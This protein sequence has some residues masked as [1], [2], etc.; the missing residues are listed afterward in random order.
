MS[1]ILVVDDEP[2]IVESLRDTLSAEDLASVGAYDHVSAEELIRNEFFP[3]ILADLRLRTTEEGLGLLAFIKTLSPDSAVIT[4]TGDADE[5]IKIRLQDLGSRMILLKPV[6]PNVLVSLVREMLTEI[7]ESAALLE[8]ETI[9]VLYATV[10]P[11]LRGLAFRRYGFSGDDADELVQRAWLLYFEKRSAIRT[12]RAWLSGTIL[13][14]CKQEIQQRCRR[15]SFDDGFEGPTATAC[16]ADDARIA[17]RQALDGL[18]D[19][20]RELSIRIGLERQSYEE[21]SAAM[22]LPIGSIGPLFI[23]AKERMRAQL[24]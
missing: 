17:I 13:N 23:R 3:V 2:M 9:D 5:V 20:G 16:G 21:V 4:I 19:R 24:S 1:R 8:D 14:L 6:D 18:D 10:T 22:N 15:R 12:A 11:Q 7:E